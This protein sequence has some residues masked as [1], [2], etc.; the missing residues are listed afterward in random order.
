[1]NSQ[2]LTM[3]ALQ[4]CRAILFH[5]LWQLGY[6]FQSCPWQFEPPPCV[7][8]VYQGH[9]RSLTQMP[10]RGSEVFETASTASREPQA[11]R[12]QSANSLTTVRCQARIPRPAVRVRPSLGAMD[13]LHVWS[14]LQ[15]KKLFHCQ[16]V[17]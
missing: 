3:H 17:D 2:S 12:R 16:L 10:R 14:I 8:S 13:M 11:S 15:A 9:T 1:M 4:F 6:L 5:I 7:L